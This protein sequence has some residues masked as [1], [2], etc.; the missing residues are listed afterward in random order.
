MNCQELDDLN[1]I[2]TVV[3]NKQNKYSVN[4]APY[5][6]V[7]FLQT[8]LIEKF[9]IEI[10]SEE[11]IK[12]LDDK[13]SVEKIREKDIQEKLHKW[14]GG[15]REVVVET[16][17]IDLLT[18]TDLVETKIANEWK[19]AVGQLLAYSKYFPNHCLVLYLFGSCPKNIQDCYQLCVEN[20]IKL[21][22][23][24]Y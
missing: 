2:K 9:N 14:W 19:H 5:Q 3:K 6:S 12:L 23:D 21:M 17:R 18:K 7:A 8:F 13:C 22:C 20:K 11:L 1:L 24:F 4:N 10:T 16:G 15:E